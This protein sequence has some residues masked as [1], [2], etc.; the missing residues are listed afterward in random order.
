MYV[1]QSRESSVGVT[2]AS[3]WDYPITKR[4]RLAFFCIVGRGQLALSQAPV[5]QGVH[6]LPQV[7]ES[8][9]LTLAYVKILTWKRLKNTGRIIDRG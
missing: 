5:T 1:T 2:F 9:I 4:Q 6:G 7:R 8:S 3:L